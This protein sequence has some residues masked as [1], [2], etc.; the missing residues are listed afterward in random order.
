VACRE[1]GSWFDVIFGECEGRLGALRQM[2]LDA[3]PGLGPRRW[4]FLME[5]GF[6]VELF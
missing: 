3:G 1:T 4:H 6:E 5:V 2:P